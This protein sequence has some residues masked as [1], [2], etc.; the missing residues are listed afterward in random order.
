MRIVKYMARKR[1]RDRQNVI[2]TAR[3]AALLR[4]T[5]VR[6]PYDPST[7]RSTEA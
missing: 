3:L 4:D 6:P 1:Q 5:V 7:R 2:S